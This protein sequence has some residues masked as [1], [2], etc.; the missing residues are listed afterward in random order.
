LTGW[1]KIHGAPYFLREEEKNIFRI[2]DRT[3]TV[4][5]YCNT[6]QMLSE[7]NN[8]F[9][10]LILGEDIQEFFPDKIQ[11]GVLVDSKSS[12]LDLQIVRG[13]RHLARLENAFYVSYNIIE[14][15]CYGEFVPFFDKTLVLPRFFNRKFDTGIDPHLV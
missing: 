11:M 10:D 1:H 8:D 14:G 2:V 6:P 3:S 4:S 7:L 13:L 12:S 5:L 9:E 15:D